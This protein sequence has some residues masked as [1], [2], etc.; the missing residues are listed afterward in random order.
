MVNVIA[1]TLIAQNGSFKAYSS[2]GRAGDGLPVSVVRFYL[3]PPKKE[4]NILQK[5][6]K[7]L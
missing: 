5:A 2:V 6:T 7:V 3:N 1:I 4:Q